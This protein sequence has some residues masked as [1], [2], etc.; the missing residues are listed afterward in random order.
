MCCVT[1]KC[2]V[3]LVA[4]PSLSL[5]S[6]TDLHPDASSIIYTVFLKVAPQA[7]ASFCP[8]NLTDLG[9]QSQHLHLDLY[10][11]KPKCHAHDLL[12]HNLALYLLY[13]PVACHLLPFHFRTLLPCYVFSLHFN[14][15]E[16]RTV[17]STIVLPSYLSISAILHSAL[18]IFQFFLSP[19]NC[20]HL[21]L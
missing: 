18:F 17:V 14:D 19:L 21:F 2:P 10:S 15:G 1:H 4:A 5:W 9:F 20:A 6:L 12:P 7:P 13:H 8:L 16:S 3:P 11:C